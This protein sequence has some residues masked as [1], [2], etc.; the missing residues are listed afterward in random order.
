MESEE[1]MSKRILLVT[2]VLIGLT[3][4]GCGL[5]TPPT[6]TPQPSPTS[7]PPPTPTP[8]PPPTP[9][10]SPI[11]TP[12]A[13]TPQGGLQSEALGDGWVRHTNIADGF[14]IELPETW[15]VLNLATEDI[16]GQLEQFAELNPELGQYIKLVVATQ[17]VEFSFFA[18]DTDP[19]SVQNNPVGV[20]TNIIRQDILAG[21]Q[22]ALLV[23]L[24]QS[25]L[26]ALEGYTV[27]ES[28]TVEIGGLEAARFL[29]EAQMTD[30]L[31][32]S[33][34]SRMIQVILPTPETCFIL[35]IGTSADRFAE[36]EERFERVVNSF[37]L[38][39]Q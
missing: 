28:S 38:V 24:V 21:A 11:P 14:S 9:T 13:A 36:H 26:A 20:S 1:K 4:L 7:T 16:E 15:L 6:P 31:G 12:P 25:Q 19:A 37:R 23:N 3:G 22:P 8:T 34:Q 18:L 5:L 39:E 30:P 27:L 35:T 17:M 10:P 2:L 33:V 32:R 29:V